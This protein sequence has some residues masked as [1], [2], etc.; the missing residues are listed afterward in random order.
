MTL[1]ASGKLAASAKIQYLCTLVCGEALRQ[2]DKLSVDIGIMTTEHLKLIILG[3]G[4]YFPP[5]NTRSK[6]KHAMGHGVRD[7]RG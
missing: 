6:Q 3:L 5:V 4:T 2:L 1:Q 7:P